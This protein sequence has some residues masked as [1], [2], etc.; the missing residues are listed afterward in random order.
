VVLFFF[1]QARAVNPPILVALGS[2]A[3]QQANPAQATK[4][5]TEQLLDYVATHPDPIICFTCSDMQLEI[6]RYIILSTYF[7]SSEGCCDMA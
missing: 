1:F 5:A 4:H 3:S 6:T 2:L 7:M